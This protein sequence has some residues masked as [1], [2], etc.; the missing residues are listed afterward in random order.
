MANTSKRACPAS[1]SGPKSVEKAP[2]ALSPSDLAFLWDDCPRC[3]YL[4]V[5]RNSPDRD[6]L[7]QVSLGASTGP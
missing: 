6:L 7:S 5:A 3:F 1:P 4:K 2:W